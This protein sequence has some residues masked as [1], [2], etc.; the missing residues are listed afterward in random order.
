MKRNIQ[1][2][3]DMMKKAESGGFEKASNEHK[4]SIITDKQNRSDA[5][6]RFI[7]NPNDESMVDEL[8]VRNYWV[9]FP[10]EGETSETMRAGGR[11]AY[12]N[13][14][15]LMLGLNVRDPMNEWIKHFWKEDE[16]RTELM[17][18]MR[19]KQNSFFVSNIAVIND[20]N[21][22]SYNGRNFVFEYRQTLKGILDSAIN[23]QF[24][25]DPV[26]PWAIDEEGANFYLRTYQKDHRKV[27]RQYD[28]SK[29]ASNSSWDGPENGDYNLES[30]YPVKGWDELVEE[31]ISL[32]P[33]DRPEWIEEINSLS[34]SSAPK[35]EEPAVKI[36]E[37]PKNTSLE[38]ASDDIDED[39]SYFDKLMKGGNG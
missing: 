22:K 15:R 10:L 37:V 39:E 9:W 16:E 28:Q 4:Y 7:G 20:A 19:L 8:G 31:M 35:K 5:E 21:E 24:G 36:T 34:D 23:P 2:L 17:E 3:R 30:L 1:E 32:V 25:D 14:S 11:R 18:K 12:V 13:Q 29:F 6:I 33:A 27:S 38:V 26:N